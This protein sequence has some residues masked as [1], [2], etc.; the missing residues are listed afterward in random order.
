MIHHCA[1]EGCPKSVEWPA[2]S[3]CPPKA[4]RGWRWGPGV[5]DGMYCEPHARRWRLSF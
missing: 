1:F 2:F 3:S 4:G 5:R